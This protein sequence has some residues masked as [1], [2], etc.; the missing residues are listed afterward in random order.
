MK[1]KLI[2]ILLAAIVI[3]PV[4][5]HSVQAVEI[6]ATGV[7]LLSSSEIGIDLLD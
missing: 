6:A 7:T 5:K 3:A 4:Y 1:T 2:L